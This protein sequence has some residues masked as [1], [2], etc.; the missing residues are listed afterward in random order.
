MASRMWLAAMVSAA[1]EIGDGAGDLE[2]A[3]VGAGGEV[4]VVHGLL[5]QDGALA[6]D[7]AVLADE[8]G[9]QGAV[10]LVTTLPL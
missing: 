9:W 1:V 8:L 7:L 10:G 4:H 3:V 2:D 6:V 5:E